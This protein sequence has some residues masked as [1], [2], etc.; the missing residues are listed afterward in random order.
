MCYIS[1]TNVFFRWLREF[2]DEPNCGHVVLLRF[3]KYLQ[4]Y[5]TA[6]NSSNNANIANSLERANNYKNKKTDMVLSKEPVRV[7]NPVRTQRRFNVHTT[8]SKRCGRCM[9]VVWTLK[10]RCVRTGSLL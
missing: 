2:I 10:Q 4:D 9:D 3:L 8:S 5:N 6:V 1:S 7:L